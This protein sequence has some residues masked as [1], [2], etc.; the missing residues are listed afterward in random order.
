MASIIRAGTTSGT[1]IN[2]SGDTTGTLALTADSGVIDASSTTGALTVPTGTTAQRPATAVVGM[3]RFNTSLAAYEVYV[4]TGAGWVALA[5]DSY[6][7]NYLIVSGG[8]GGS[9]AG[10][11]AG[12]LLANS[13]TVF[14]STAY[15]VTIGG[16]GAGQSALNTTGTN[17]SDSVFSIVSTTAVSYTHLTLPTICSV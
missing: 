10:A 7:V 6:S 2:V 14:S 4:G 16:G 9:F 12:G 13:I 5:T 1:A 8:G 15:T 17:G 3:T 11:G